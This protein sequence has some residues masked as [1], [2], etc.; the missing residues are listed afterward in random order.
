[1]EIGRN[2]EKVPSLGDGGPLDHGGP[3]SVFS[4]WLWNQFL[5]KTR[6]N[7]VCLALAAHVFM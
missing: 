1:M 4:G 5:F 6:N 2:Y 7:N 3:T